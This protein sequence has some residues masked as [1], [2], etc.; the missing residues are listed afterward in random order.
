MVRDAPTPSSLNARAESLTVLAQAQL[1]RTAP[2]DRKATLS[3]AT[4]RRTFA[5]LLLLAR[6]RD[7][8]ESW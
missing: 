4:D 6:R 1:T 7:L 5:A 8:A 2:N 3:G